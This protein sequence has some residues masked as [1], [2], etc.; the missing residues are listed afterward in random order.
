MLPLRLKQRRSLPAANIEL[1]KQVLLASFLEENVVLRDLALK[2]KG[3]QR[4]LQGRVPGIQTLHAPGK[5]KQKPQCVASEKSDRTGVER[6]CQ[7]VSA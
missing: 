6:V 7:P 3:A 4:N 1:G 5:R 2:E